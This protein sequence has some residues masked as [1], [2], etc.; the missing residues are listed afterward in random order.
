MRTNIL[1]AF[2]DLEKGKPAAEGE[3]RTWGGQKFRKQGKEWVKVTEQKG[4]KAEEQTSTSGG[5]KEENTQEKQ[6]AIKADSQDENHPYEHVRNSMTHEELSNKVLDVLNNTAPGK[7]GEMGVQLYKLGLKPSEIVDVSGAKIAT[8]LFHLNNFKASGEHTQLQNAAK[9][10]QAS[11]KKEAAPEKEQKKNEK[12]QEDQGPNIIPYEKL[13][14]I[15]VKD[16]WDSYETFGHMMCSGMGKSM[17]AY[18]SGGVGKTYTLMGEGQVFDQYGMKPFNEDEH[19]KEN[20]KEKNLNKDAYDYVK[21]TGKVSAVEMYKKLFEHNG[22]IVVFDD[23]DSVLEDD[24]AVNVLKGALDTSGDGTVEWATKGDILSD[25]TNVEGTT[26]S[27]KGHK[28]PKRFKFN[29]QVL[30][31]SNKDHTDMPQ[32]LLSRGLTVDLTMNADET[33]ERMKSIYPKMKFKD[34]KGNEINVSKEDKDE[35]F[36][37]LDKHKNDLDPADLNMRTFQKVALI[38]KTLEDKGSNI[39]W[40]KT[41]AAMLKK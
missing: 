20:D 30:F 17:I 14:E 11:S 6:K 39:D 4:P 29:G 37:F 40:K 3:E 22:K 41:A 7:K 13:P 32:A 23:C 24:N 18:G 21:V 2:I 35:V 33:V 26:K 12:D 8:L 36:S 31:I 28:I 27:D 5:G 16:K 10:D 9:Q 1:S 19:I 15:S 25:Y 38:K 34:P